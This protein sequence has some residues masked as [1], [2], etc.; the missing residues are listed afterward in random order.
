MDFSKG[1]PE[2][3]KRRGKV[4][5]APVRRALQTRGTR[6]TSRDGLL[7]EHRHIR[8]VLEELKLEVLSGLGSTS[9]ERRGADDDGA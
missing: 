2:E 4:R 1:T 9:V 7:D 3:T 8:E 5:Q 6:L